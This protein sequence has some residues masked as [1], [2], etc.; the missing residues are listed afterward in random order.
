MKKKVFLLIIFIF[1]ICSFSVSAGL[2]NKIPIPPPLTIG[3]LETLFCKLNGTCYIQELFTVN[4]TTIN[5][6]NTSQ[7]CLNDSCINNWG[8]ITLFMDDMF[9]NIT[10]DTMTGDLKMDAEIDMNRNRIHD[11]GEIVMTTNGSLRGFASTGVTFRD[12]IYSGASCSYDIGNDTKRFKNLYLCG[13]A[14]IEGN[15][16]ADY[17]FGDGSLLTGIASGGNSSWNESYARELIIESNNSMR[18]YVD[19][20]NTTMTTY[21]DAIFV[22]LTVTEYDGSD[23]GGVDGDIART[24]ATSGVAWIIVD[25]ITLQND[26]DYNM[27][28]NTITFINM[29]WDEMKVTVWD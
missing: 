25:G 17:Y 6:Y 22:P 10:G 15:V 29:M 27:T 3:N 13:N 21:V 23:C 12:D 26:T 16:S 19:F 11:V 5:I 28:G 7:I 1:L 14:S 2:F 24:L 9:V 20:Q 4:L 18:D 8:N